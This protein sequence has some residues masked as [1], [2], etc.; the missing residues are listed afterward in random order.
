MINH[1][2]NKIPYKSSKEFINEIL[3]LRA[4]TKKIKNLSK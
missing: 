1:L 3:D 4:Y 2:Q